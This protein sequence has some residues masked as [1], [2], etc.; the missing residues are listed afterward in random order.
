MKDYVYYSKVA[1]VK[2]QSGEILHPLEDITSRLKQLK[3]WLS[4]QPGH[5]THLSNL[6]QWFWENWG[7]CITDI[8][9]Y[10]K[11]IKEKGM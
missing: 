2:Q 1:N 4:E 3:D 8:E 10:M 7:E 11:Y 5:P 6:P 9:D